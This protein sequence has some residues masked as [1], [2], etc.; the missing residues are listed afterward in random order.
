MFA[1]NRLALTA[2]LFL[3]LA[4]V[5]MPSDGLCAGEGAAITQTPE[6]VPETDIRVKPEKT[7]TRKAAKPVVKLN[8][9]MARNLKNLL[10]T[11]RIQVGNKEMTV[12][13]F[14][15]KSRAEQKKGLARNKAMEGSPAVSM[16]A[17]QKE[18]DQ[19]EAARLKAANAK[20]KTEMAKLGKQPARV[21]PPRSA[22]AIKSEAL[23]IQKRVRGGTA[24]P[25]DNARV[26]KLFDQYQQLK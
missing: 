24:T 9:E 17:L 1:M 10:D 15:K 20:V 11:Q 21:S 2:I 13:E 3:G 6:T 4:V 19:Q 23:A 5:F 25:A 18:F 8:K 12:R 22:E 7:T 14:K 26:K 16:E